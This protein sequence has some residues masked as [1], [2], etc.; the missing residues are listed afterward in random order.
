M[1]FFPAT[2]HFEEDFELGLLF[3]LRGARK[4]PSDVVVISIDREA[5]ERLNVPQ[6][7]DRWPRSLHAELIDHL[8]HEGARVIVLDMYFIEP[9]SGEANAA[10]AAAIRNARNVVLAEPLRLDEVPASS[11]VDSSAAHRV[12][13]PLRTIAPISEAAFA[14]APFVLDQSILDVSGQCGRCPNVPGGDIPTLCFTRLSSLPCV[15]PKSQSAEC[16][17]ATDGYSYRPQSARRR[18]VYERYPGN[19]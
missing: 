6:N 18:E 5:S 8:V 12:V 1:S 9:R 14:T 3:K 10:L 15:A 11:L 19:L 16:Q 4:A 7:P 2:H 13:K 17:K